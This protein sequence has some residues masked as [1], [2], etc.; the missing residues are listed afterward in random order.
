MTRNGR[1]GYEG[2]PDSGFTLVEALFTAILLALLASGISALYVSGLQA[3]DGQA[4]VMLLDSRLRGRMEIL[5]G[6][7]FDQILAG[8]NVSHRDVAVV[9]G[10]QRQDSRYDVLNPRKCGSIKGR[11]VVAAH[12]V[13]G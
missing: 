4:D 6:R 11:P 5:V 7:P 10:N 12:R 3:L 13:S 9:L 1:F 8:L 2:L